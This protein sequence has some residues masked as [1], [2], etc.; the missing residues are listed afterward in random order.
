MRLLLVHGIA[1]GEKNPA[2]LKDEWVDALNRGFK[3]QTLALPAGTQIDMPF[4][5]KTLDGFVEQFDAPHDAQEKGGKDADYARF[6]R[7]VTM[8]AAHEAKIP[9]ADIEAEYVQQF[10]QIQ[11]NEKGPQNWGWVQA[12]LSFLDNRSSGTSVG[13]FS[14][15]LKEVYVYT[16]RDI[17]TQA[18]NKIVD[19]ILTDEPTVVVGHSLGS[20]VA[21]NVLIS[22]K[23][24]QVPQFITVGSPL[25]IKGIRDSLKSPLSHPATTGKWY[26]AY[27]ERDVVALNP[28]KGKYFPIADPKIV[29]VSTLRNITDN[30]HGIV[31]YIDQ[32][33]VVSAI[34]SGLTS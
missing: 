22:R 15:F 5:G 29:N 10:G 27:D 19:G 31:S 34:V 8:E 6:V 9:D 12:T 14:R 13:L 26:N 32:P 18:I 24:R 21:Y 2:A 25:G 33:G 23:V 7:D 11:A 1:Q 20:V 17:A 30:H 16:R 28:L 4:Y 3:N